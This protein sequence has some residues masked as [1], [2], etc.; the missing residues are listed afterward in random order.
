MHS[1]DIVSK[2]NTQELTNAV[3][4]TIK[5]IQTRY[6]F[7]GTKSTVEQGKEELVILADDD[8][9]MKA[10]I[11][12]LQNKMIKRGVPI[13]ALKYG[14][15]EEA[16]GGMVRMSIKLQQGIEQENAKKIVAQIK[17]TKLK[18]QAAI[19]GDQVRVSGK[20]IDDLQTVMKM[21]KEKD[22]DFAMQFE[23]YR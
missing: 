14:K 22:L 15:Q 11:D 2:I 21:L 6:D 16:S 20:S 5:E 12:I 8:F 10:I 4:Q 9:K 23:N 13:K 7:K 18:I 17:E 3:Q 1:F 19:Q